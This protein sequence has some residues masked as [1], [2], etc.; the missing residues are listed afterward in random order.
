MELAELFSK[1]GL[2]AKAHETLAE[3]DLACHKIPEADLQKM[4]VEKVR[5]M[6]DK[7]PKGNGK[8]SN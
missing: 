7:L 2:H 5:T 4:A 3:A 6:M 8:K 1:A